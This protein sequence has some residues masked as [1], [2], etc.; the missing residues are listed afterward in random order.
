MNDQK[1]VAADYNDA[2]TIDVHSIFK[3]IQGEG[4]FC[5]QRA[6]FIR[7]WGCNLRCPGCDTEYTALRVLYTPAS[8][9]AVVQGR[10]FDWPRGALIVLTGG[11]P[12][13]QNVVPAIYELLTAGYRVQVETNGVLAPPNLEML[14]HFKSFSIVCSPKTSRISDAIAKRAMAF[15]YV[16]RATEVC[17]ED[18]LPTLALGHPASPM[19]ARPQ[20]VVPIYIQPMDEHDEVFSRANL[21][22]AIASTMANG[23]TLQIQIHKIIGLD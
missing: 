1:P 13:R 16:L 3:T 11:E 7:L 9:L 12:F 15:K 18:G 17:A 21:D 14:D 5:G 8:L 22:A 20:R 10:C 4:P 6:L 2:A 19:I 23:Y